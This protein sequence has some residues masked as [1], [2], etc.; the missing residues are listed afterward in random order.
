MYKRLLLKDSLFEM[1]LLAVLVG[2]IAGLGAV[3]FRAMIGFFHNIAF[4]G[5]LSF[6]YNANEHTPSSPWGAA[7]IL[8]PVVGSIFVSFLI[9]KFAPEAKGH[10]VPEI[11]DSIY[12]NRGIIRPVVAV[13]KSLAS[14]LTISTGGSVGREGPIAQIGAS[15]GST[16]GQIIRMPD[17]QRI[18]LVGAGAGAGIAATFNTPIGGLLFAIEL[19][20]PEI[21]ARSLIPVA[22][23]TGTATSIGRIFFGDTPSFNIPALTLPTVHALQAGVFITYAFL[24]LMLGMAALLFILAIYGMED[25][26]EKM[27]G[28]YYTRHMFGMLMIGLMMYLFMSWFGHYYIQGVGYSTVQDI[29][30]KN[31]TVP[32]L[33]LLL[34]GAKLLATSITLGSGGSGGIFSPS[35]FLGATLAGGYGLLL[36]HAYPTLQLDIVGMAVVGMAGFVGAATG[37]VMTAIVMIFEMTRDYNIIIPLMITVSI[38]Y[39]IRRLLFD[40]SIY[41]L[42]LTR[43]GHTIPQSMQT[44]WS[45]SQTAGSVVSRP[46]A[47]AANDEE[48]LEVASRVARTPHILLTEDGIVKGVL[49]AEQIRK[50]RRSNM[51]LTDLAGSPYIVVAA[52]TSLLDV[53]TMMRNKDAEVAIITQDGELENVEDVMGILSLAEVARATNLPPHISQSNPS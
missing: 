32:S 1:A 23:A 41:S 19:I 10:G 38:A 33:L 47:Q 35:L 25:L 3:V 45:V 6:F 27:P 5:K 21:S 49:S 9:Q 36:N 13:V 2:I 12:Y 24:G 22:L 17:W 26:F 16:L 7:I 44:Y 14:A 42:K 28:N 46:I 29:L 11:V 43:R 50:A 37:A 51:K 18:T 53:F 34:F 40:D 4:L 52:G 48:L 31:L 15:F 8:V 20:I 39:G 30:M